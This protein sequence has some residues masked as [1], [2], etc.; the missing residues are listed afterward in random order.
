MD[1]I[2]IK[3]QQSVLQE[4]GFPRSRMGPDVTGVPK[5]IEAANIDEAAAALDEEYGGELVEAIKKVKEREKMVIKNGV[6]EII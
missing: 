4:K 3:Q 1:A 5:D 2:E 6:S